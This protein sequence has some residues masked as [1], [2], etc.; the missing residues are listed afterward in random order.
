MTARYKETLKEVKKQLEALEQD[1]S[2]KLQILEEIL[3]L[4]EDIGS[5]YHSA[6]PK[7]KRDYLNL[8]I[9]SFKIRGGEIVDC[10]LSPDVKDLIEQGSVRVRKNGL[11]G[12]D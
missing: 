4:A 10:E 11:P 6:L 3:T 12:L 7:Q 1:Y 5:A 2:G 9:S 8:F